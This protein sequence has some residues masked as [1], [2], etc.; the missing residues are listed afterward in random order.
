[1]LR[2]PVSVSNVSILS[3]IIPS[4]SVIQASSVLNAVVCRLT[5]LFKSAIFQDIK[6]FKFDEF[7]FAVNGLF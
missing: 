3:L 7:K 2:I 1:M 6:Q 5:D 4:Y